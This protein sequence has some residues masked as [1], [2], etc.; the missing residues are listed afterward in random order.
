MDSLSE[1]GNSIIIIII[2]II[3][4]LFSMASTLVNLLSPYFIL[5]TYGISLKQ[6]V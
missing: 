4:E 5:R 2:I 3:T 1:R 6:G